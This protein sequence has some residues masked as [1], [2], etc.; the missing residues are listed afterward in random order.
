[1]T[2]DEDAVAT[3][4]L[5]FGKKTLI[6]IPSGFMSLNDAYLRAI[7]LAAFCHLGGRFTIA[8]VVLYSN[9][10]DIR[11]KNP[12]RAK[13]TCQAECLPLVLVH[14]FDDIAE[15]TRRVDGGG[16]AVAKEEV[17]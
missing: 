12:V 14:G 11:M 15:A 1:M 10:L 9:L 4:I 17:A 6:K 5:E 13:D 16:M 3:N 2:D 8:S 7:I